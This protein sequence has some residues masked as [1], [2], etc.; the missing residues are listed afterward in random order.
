MP[1]VDY[2][3]SLQHRDN[4]NIGAKSLEKDLLE[5][6]SILVDFIHYNGLTTVEKIKEVRE[7]SKPRAGS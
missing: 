5:L 2:H 7:A 1:D 4:V 3:I 6:A